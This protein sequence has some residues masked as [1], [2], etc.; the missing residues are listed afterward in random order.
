[1]RCF[2]AYF[3]I[4]FFSIA[5]SKNIDQLILEFFK[6]REYTKGYLLEA[7]ALCALNEMQKKV[8]EM[9]RG[10]LSDGYSLSYTL[11]PGSHRLP[12]VSTTMC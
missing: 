12:I 3:F 7:T 10:Q 1:M 8:R 4:L 6:G 2:T 5:L 9:H 11:T